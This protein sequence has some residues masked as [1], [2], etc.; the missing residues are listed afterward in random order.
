MTHTLSYRFSLH[1]LQ[2]GDELYIKGY[3]SGNT[4]GQNT[5][6]GIICVSEKVCVCVCVCVCVVNWIFK[7]NSLFALVYSGIVC[8]TG[9]LFWRLVLFL[10]NICSLPL[11][12][13]QFLKKGIATQA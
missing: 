2:E 7:P 13:K 12:F 11:T 9:K 1:G 10:E 8:Y 5:L 3:H 6:S 4:T